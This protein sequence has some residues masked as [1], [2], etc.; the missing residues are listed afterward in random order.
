M[1][2][3][4][5]LKVLARTNILQGALIPNA[6]KSMIKLFVNSV[7]DTALARNRCALAVERY[8]R[9]LVL[10]QKCLSRC[11][12]GGE[13]ELCQQVAVWWVAA[14][15]ERRIRMVSDRRLRA[16]PALRG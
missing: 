6:D 12:L 16:L 15:H 8:L 4:P 3:S 1:C 2:S 10:L 13:T 5:D 9:G 7:I 14:L 11:E